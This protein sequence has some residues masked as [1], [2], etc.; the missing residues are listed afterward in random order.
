MILV[1]TSVLIDYLKGNSNTAQEKFD[2]ILKK[3]IPYSIHYVIFQEVLQGAKNEREYALLTEY[4]ETIP[5]LELLYGKES[6][7][8]A[9][10]LS[11][12]CRKQGVPVKSTIDFLIARLAIENKVPLLHND[13]DF[14]RIAGVDDGLKCY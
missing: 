3:Q 7:A 8:K 10:Y 5:F 9:A 14:T 11:L 2:F 6:Y 1:D 12:R 4:L 13:M